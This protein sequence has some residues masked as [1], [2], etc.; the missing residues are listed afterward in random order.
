MWKILEIG[1][2]FPLNHWHYREHYKTTFL[3]SAV[4][5][6]RLIQFGPAVDRH[7]I[8]VAVRVRVQMEMS[9]VKH[10]FLRRFHIWNARII[11]LK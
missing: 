2:L 10:E 6:D 4:P 1:A 7:V 3:T 9:K 8:V 5:S 11:L